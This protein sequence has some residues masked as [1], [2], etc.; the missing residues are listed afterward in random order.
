MLA[1]I[2]EGSK[3]CGV[4]MT[5]RY[6]IILVITLVNLSA[7]ASSPYVKV[8]VGLSP[9]GN[10]QA[11]TG[12][13]T[14]FAYKTK[15]GVRAENVKIDLR[16]LKTG[17]PLR[18]KHTKEHLVTN[19]Y[20]QAKLIKAIG[21]GGK[22]EALIEIKGKKKKVKGT[23]SIEGKTLKARFPVKLADFGIKNIRYMGMG[24]KDEVTI[25]VDLPLQAEPR[26]PASQRKTQ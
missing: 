4:S 9:A 2:K 17:L 18:D 23:Y 13:V 1:I 3:G 20:P 11:E 24:V 16:S 12:R 26:Q 19:K 15:N 14:G 10:F 8:D 25:N 7:W 21:K 6:L 5:G 22:G